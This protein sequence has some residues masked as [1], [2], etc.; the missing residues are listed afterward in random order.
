M[1]QNALLTQVH[2]H[3]FPPS[4]GVPSISLI[5][6]VTF[7]QHVL[8]DPQVDEY[9]KSVFIKGLKWV[10]NTAKELYGKN[11]IDADF[12]EKEA[13]L[14]DLATYSR[15]EKWISLNLTYIFE[16]LLADPI[17]NV[18]TAEKGWDWLH[19]QEGYPRPNQKTKYQY[20]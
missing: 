20:L 6:S 13:C 4:E 8:N 19:H 12:N 17:Y 7:C 9:D 10:N 2:E 18:N 1:R 11:F 14:K 3:L 16:A 5:K 15:G